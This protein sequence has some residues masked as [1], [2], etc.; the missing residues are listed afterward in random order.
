MQTESKPDLTLL[1]D[2]H[3]SELAVA[4]VI[5]VEAADVTYR[6]STEQDGLRLTHDVVE[7]IVKDVR[8][9][10]YERSLCLSELCSTD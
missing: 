3:T 8:Y 7:E 9:F 2:Q 4:Y 1:A 6:P 5:A 10:P